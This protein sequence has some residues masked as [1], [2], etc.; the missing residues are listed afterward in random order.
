MALTR[1]KLTAFRNL[2]DAEI[3]PASG[4]NLLI[5]MNASGKTS[6]L[7]AIYLLSLAR[8]FRSKRL[9]TLIHH[10]EG[11]F[12][13]FAE[14]AQPQTQIK[15]TL[16]I[17]RQQHAPETEILFQGQKPQGVAELARH[18]PVQLINPDAFRLLEGSPKDRRQFLDWG[19]FHTQPLFMSAW[20]RFQ[21]ALRQ[22]NSLLRHARIDPLE[23]RLWDQEVATTGELISTLRAEYLDRLRPIFSQ[24]LMRLTEL[25]QIDIHYQRGWDKQVDLSSYLA[26][27]LAKDKEQGFTQGGP[28]RAELRVTASGRL[29]VDVLSRGQQ[30]CVVSALKLAQGALLAEQT[31]QHC[32]YIID[33]L[34]AELDIQHRQLFCELLEEQNTQVFITAVEAQAMQQDWKH[35]DRMAWFHVKHGKI[36]PTQ[37]SSIS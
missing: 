4:I 24:F 5:G 27:A 17:Q 3:R 15:T 10:D 25:Q 31:G 32:T 26:S 33:D 1:L 37:F 6:V 7:E 29:A 12:T 20:Q 18:F 36:Q 21:R 13:V 16:G 19:V 11:A 28:Q 23:L 35:S 22:R 34:P 9:K 8:S 2:L 14:F 30:K